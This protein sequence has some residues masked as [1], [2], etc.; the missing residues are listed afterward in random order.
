MSVN[1]EVAQ[2][3][4]KSVTKNLKRKKMCATI[5]DNIWVENLPVA[6]MGSLSSK[7]WGFKYVLCVMHSTNML[8]LNH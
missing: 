2:K 8:G 7:N 4:H 6:E 5:K 3:L 1:E